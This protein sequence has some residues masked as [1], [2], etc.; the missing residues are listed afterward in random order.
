MEKSVLKCLFIGAMVF[1]FW[2]VSLSIMGIVNDRNELSEATQTEIAESWSKRQ[3][4]VGPIICVPVIDE[5]KE[6]A[7]PY[8]CMY[9]LP[10]RLEMTSDIESEILHRGIFDASVYRT[11][12]SG[13]GT[14]NLKE[15]KLQGVMAGSSKPIRYDWSNA[16]IIAAIGDRRGIEEGLKVKIGDNALE[17]NQFFYNYGN[18]NLENVFYRSSE[19]ICKV[20]DLTALL[21]DEAVPFE[22]T[23]E[24]KGS[25]ELN[26]SPIGQTSVIT[27]QGNCQDPSFNG[28]MLPSNREVT[29]NGFKATWKISSLNRN[30]VDQV[31][32]AG[33]QQQGFQSIGTKLLIQGGQYTQTNRALK[34]SFLV[35]LLSLV[36]V[37]V[38]EMCVKRSINILSYLLIGAALVLFY[39]ML[40]SFSEW[41]GFT[42]SYFLSALLILGMVYLYLK[43]IIKENH[44]AMAAC[45]FMALIGTLGLFVILGV[46]M[47]FSLRFVSEKKME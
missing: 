43:A 34:Y 37:F 22:I 5:S 16:Q 9:V 27:M 44:V 1:V 7:L 38:A 30:D 33:N 12:I 23:A 42:M 25:H 39:L 41:I 17:L 24:L 35:L 32:Y 45:M 2:L 4:F 15:M 14:F 6:N 8:T 19:P 10:E 13:K 31:F 3:D 47:F 36:S 40:L 18:T 29:D 28:F 21:N 11:R 20:A 26:I 46:A